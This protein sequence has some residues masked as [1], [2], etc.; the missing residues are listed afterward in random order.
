MAS[1]LEIHPTEMVKKMEKK[2]L[3]FFKRLDAIFLVTIGLNAVLSIV[4]KFL[5]RLDD[6]SVSYDVY[7]TSR[8]VISVKPL[9][10]SRSSSL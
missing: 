1:T 9:L 10:T 7:Y 2:F 8:K 6:Y 5:S 4:K 3:I